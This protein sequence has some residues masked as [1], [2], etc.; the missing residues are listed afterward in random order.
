MVK[1]TNLHERT[2]IPVASASALL[3]AAVHTGWLRVGWGG[4]ASADQ[5]R[6]YPA[7]PSLPFLSL[8]LPHPT[9]LPQLIRPRS[10]TQGGGAGCGRY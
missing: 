6:V 10:I 8:R 5:H 1:R 9:P 2:V 3:Q 7:T 4:A